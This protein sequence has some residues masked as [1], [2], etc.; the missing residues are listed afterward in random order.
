ML[1][2]GFLAALAS[3]A[4]AACTT[5][6]IKMSDDV[7]RPPAG[8]RV[9]L[10]EPDIQ[11]AILT[12]VGLTEPRADWSKSA[13][14]NV[15]Q[16][17]G[18][19]LRARSHTF[20]QAAADPSAPGQVGQLFRL[21]EA[22][23][24]SILAVSYGAYPLPTKEGGFDWTLGEGAQAL[25]RTYDAD[26]AL[27]VFGNGTHAS[28]GRVVAAIGMTLLGAP[29]SLGSQ[30]LFASLVELKTGRVVWFNRV[31]AGPGADMREADGARDMV[32]S[33]LKN[34]PL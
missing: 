27:F 22:V 29:M 16:A 15:G 19:A 17:I 14:D 25:G 26:Y 9:L 33:L 18:E 5:T 32:G 11:L 21:H 13:K 24:A 7:A 31:Q 28:S 12:T 30:Q 2:R 8:T 20:K 10:L 6:Q 3:L 23:G 4:L 34:I 1:R